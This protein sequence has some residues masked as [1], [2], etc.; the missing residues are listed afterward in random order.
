[1][2]INANMTVMDTCIAMGEGNPGAI[3]CAIEMMNNGMFLDLLMLDTKEVYGEKLYMLWNDCCD[4]D[5]EK[6]KKTLELIRAGEI[7]DAQLHANL[8]QCRAT[9]FI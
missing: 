3:V 2:K 1:M 4:R 6:F 7:T 5:M 8:S 9:S